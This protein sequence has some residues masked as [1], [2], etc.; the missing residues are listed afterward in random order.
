MRSVPVDNVEIIFAAESI[1]QPASMMGHVMLKVSG[2]N[3]T[4]AIPVEHVVSFFTRMNDVTPPDLVLKTFITGKEGLYSLTPYEQ[5]RN[6]YLFIENRN[7]WEYKLKLDSRQKRILQYHLYELRNIKFTYY[8]HSFNCATFIRDL[9]AVTEPRLS[10]A[11]SLWV[12][13]LDVIRT[14]KE[15]DL[16]DSRQLRYTKRWFIKKILTFESF[17]QKKLKHIKNYEWDFLNTQNDTAS[18]KHYILAKAY[19]GFGLEE[20]TRTTEE[21]REGNNNLRQYFGSQ[22][23]DVEVSFENLKG[24]EETIQ[25]S[26]ISI[27][28][29]SNPAFNGLRYS[30]LPV[31]H[32]LE[33]SLAGYA[34][35]SDVVLGEVSFLTN[36][37]KNNTLLYSFELFKL[38]SYQVSDYLTGGYS[39]QIHVGYNHF[40]DED[41]NFIPA[42]YVKAGLGKTY[43]VFDDLDFYVNGSFLSRYENR[44]LFYTSL[45]SGLILRGIFNTKTIINLS[46]ITRFNDNPIDLFTLRQT[47]TLRNIVFGVSYENPIQIRGRENWNLFV[48]FLF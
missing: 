7:L 44:V 24:P 42:S 34:F 3:N 17:D 39:H 18:S 15:Y 4:K 21:W 30:F 28:Y 36:V 20:G 45:D 5:T 29:S 41:N 14:I 6:Y 2:K 33:D 19:N 48:K 11:G 26:Q 27:G 22:A 47:L 13:P 31:S 35:E 37:R 43:R 10:K 23:E 32:R 46:R 16:F 9:L 12:T 8:F 38:Q 25:D 1:S 40:Y